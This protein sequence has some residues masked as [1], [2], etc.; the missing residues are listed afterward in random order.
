MHS[1]SDEQ[2]GPSDEE[3]MTP[4]EVLMK[5]TNAWL[6][7][8]MSPELL[9]PLES[10][11]ECL[12]EQ[13]RLEEDKF[14]KLPPRDETVRHMQLEVER[15]RFLVASYLRTRLAKIQKY[16]WFINDQ[17]SKRAPSSKS[18][19]MPEEYKFLREYIAVVEGHLSTAALSHMPIV[20]KTLRPE[21]MMVTPN[22]DSFVFLRVNKPADIAVE[23]AEGTRSQQVSLRPGN[24]MII[25]YRPVSHLLSTNDVQLV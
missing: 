3:T 24:Q 22:L 13:I 2:F 4:Y 20:V 18:R 12:L 21:V 23:D 19:L 11:V 7:E 8:K 5:L 16:C 9:L 1:S 6:N 14:S 25:K 15:V 10:E 17:E